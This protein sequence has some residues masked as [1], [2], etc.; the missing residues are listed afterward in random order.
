MASGAILDPDAKV[1]A[2]ISCGLAT[3]PQEITIK[4]KPEQR[5][6]V[7]C[8]AGMEGIPSWIS[9]SYQAFQGAKNLPLPAHL[10]A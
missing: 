4:V 9:P 10:N 2:S 8:I 6:K 7:W 3:N 5:G 1:A